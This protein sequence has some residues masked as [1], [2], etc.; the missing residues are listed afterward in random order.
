M[1]EVTDSAA[2]WV[3]LAFVWLAS[4]VTCTVALLARGRTVLHAC[5]AAIFLG[6]L[7]LPFLFRAPRRTLHL[8]A[9]AASVV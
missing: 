3:A 6:P 9:V 2:A 1:V 5:A 4:I 8:G 7:G